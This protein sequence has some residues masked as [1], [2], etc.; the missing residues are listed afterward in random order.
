VVVKAMPENL[1]GALGVSPGVRRLFVID[2]LKVFRE[3]SGAA[4]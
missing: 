2:G 1:A 4:V 3:Q